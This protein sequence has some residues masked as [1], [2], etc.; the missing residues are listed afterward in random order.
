MGTDSVLV[1]G[2]GG[3]IGGAVA[4]CFARLGCAVVG[5]DR[6]LPPGFDLPF[7]SHDLP[8]PHR[9]YQ[10]IRKHRVNKIVHAGGVSGPML[11]NDSPNRIVQIN[12]EGLTGLLEAA[13]IEGI[14]R[15][16]GFSSV[17]A[18]GDHP[19]LSEIT[20]K[21]WLNPSSVYGATKA[22]GDALVNAYY[23]SHGVDMVTFRVAGG[24]GPGRVTPCLIRL[25]IE[26]ALQGR[27]S[28]V[29]DDP[30]RTR[31]YIFVD[32]VVDAVML[33]MDQSA[34]PQRTYNIGPGVIHTARDVIDTVQACLPSAEAEIDAAGMQW[35]SFGIGLLNIDAARR[36]FGFNPAVDLAQGVQKTLDWVLQREAKS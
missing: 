11:L 19:D 20:E 32:D 13:R 5:M 9:W 14:E 21:S 36:D 25:L 27:K 8:D 22:A 28:L 10:V 33:A 34:L 35:N 15:I 24:Y 3:L 30:R 4:R 17:V 7:I 18:Y 16:I 12:L 6:S 26:D 2:V 31:Q 23:L 1:T 29:C